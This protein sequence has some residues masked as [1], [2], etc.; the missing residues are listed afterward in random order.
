MN[1]FC[2]WK[3][4]QLIFSLIF[5]VNSW[6]QSGSDF[7]PIRTLKSSIPSRHIGLNIE[8]QSEPQN[9]H[10][11]NQ[12]YAIYRNKPQ[13]HGIKTKIVGLITKF[14]MIYYDWTDGRSI[15]LQVCHITFKDVKRFKQVHERDKDREQTTLQRN[16][17]LYSR[18]RLRRKRK[19]YPKNCNNL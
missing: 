5:S 8:G 12:T 10:R 16:V 19:F 15:G 4:N 11:Y 13:E 18:N 2:R 7:T 14:Q 6:Q 9:K 3:K 1:H 17:F